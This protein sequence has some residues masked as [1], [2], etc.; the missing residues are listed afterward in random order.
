LNPIQVEEILFELVVMISTRSINC[1]RF[2]A[3]GGYQALHQ[4]LSRVIR[5][6][7]FHLD[8]TPIL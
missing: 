5:R 7:D 1:R 8:L 3:K 2:L 6:P 4:Y